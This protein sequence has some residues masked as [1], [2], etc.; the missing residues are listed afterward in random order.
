MSQEPVPFR[1][2]IVKHY[3][4]RGTLRQY[5]LANAT[6]FTCGRCGA[7]KTAKLVATVDGAWEPLLCNGC[8]GWLL[9]VWK[10]K[11]SALSETERDAELTRLLR[12]QVTDAQVR[13]A[14]TRLVQLGTWYTQLLPEAMTMLATVEVVVEAF[15]ERAATSLD[16]SAAVIGLCKAVEVEVVG[17]VAAPLRRATDGID[18]SQDRSTRGFKYML[19]FCVQGREITMG[20]VAYFLRTLMDVPRRESPLTS[21]ARQLGSRWPRSD[22]VFSPSGLAD[23][24]QTLTSE[25]RNPAAHTGVLSPG[26]YAVCLDRVRGTNGLLPRLL[27]A[28]TPARR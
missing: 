4:P 15:R 13:H 2:D 17:L 6:S 23:S 7:D 26:D 3:P 18:L 22:W 11:T 19:D 24:L 21:A 25:H 10:V 27:D 1:L 9:S 28:V 16:W 20:Q 8:Y 14:G 12:N 5:R